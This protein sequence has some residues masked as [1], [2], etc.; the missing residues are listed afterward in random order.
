MVKDFSFKNNGMA[1]VK[2]LG[3]LSQNLIFQKKDF[4][5]L[6]LQMIKGDEIPANA[7]LFK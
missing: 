3:N 1:A 5:D 6:N 7:I 2:I 4:K